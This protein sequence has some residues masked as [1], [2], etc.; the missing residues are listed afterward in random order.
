MNE[1]KNTLLDC[2]KIAKE[3]YVEVTEK[4]GQL[5]QELTQH[6]ET[7]VDAVFSLNSS[8]IENE[9]TYRVL[10]DIND[11][12][13]SLLQDGF[14]RFENSFARKHKNLSNFTVTLFGRTKAGKSTI[15]EALTNGDGTSIGKGAQRTTRDVKEYFWNHLRILDTPG[16]DAYKGIEDEKMAFSQ[17]DQTDLILFLVTSDSIEESEFK[18]LAHIRRENKPVIILLN[19]LYDLNHP[20]KRKRFLKNP[21]K[22]VSL[23]AIEGHLH[24]LQFLSKKHFNIGNIEIIPIHALAAYESNGLIGEEKDILYKAS[25]FEY[26]KRTITSNIQSTGKQKRV[27]SFRDS[28]ISHLENSI[29]SIYAESCET[30]GPQ[31]VLMR[32][33]QKELSRWF[34]NFIPEKNTEIEQKIDELYD[35]L[36]Q[37]LDSFIDKHIQN[38]HFGKK[39]NQKVNSEIT[40]AQ[41]RKIY[42]SITN[43]ANRYLKEFFSEFQFDLDLSLSELRSELQGVKKGTTA[44]TVKWSGAAIGTASAIILSTMVANSWNPIGWGLAAVAAG[45][46]IFRMFYDD[47]TKRFNR[48]KARIKSNILSSLRKNKIELRNLLK[49][50]FSREITEGLK[51]KIVSDLNRQTIKLGNLLKEYEAIT[52]NIEKEI[53]RANFA[54][55]TR[56]L[57]LQNIDGSY[58]IKEIQ[59]IYRVQG[60]MSKLVLAENFEFLSTSDRQ[61]FEKVFG[62]KIVDVHFS[63]D[64]KQYLLNS[65]TVE[66]E[67]VDKISYEDALI[68]IDVKQMKAERIYGSEGSNLHLA[69]KI[70]KNKIQ[71][72]L[73]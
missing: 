50:W 23:E 47:D 27:Q 62:E 69:Q 56:L 6:Q 11:K 28:Y 29:K 1:Y 46:G 30:L 67:D 51:K 2:S 25:N 61:V 7:L 58:K 21:Q 34:N 22:A 55:M 49:S 68:T 60:L 43:D 41:I 38:P 26:F 5:K 18:K 8:S 24:R 44:K 39:W 3:E 53:E 72:N 71:V 37:D 54:L 42:E 59:N 16:F 36:F 9:S 70:L 35:P 32:K 19:V 14:T 17:L 12:T 64:R 33:K 52:E 66:E 57:A 45:L 31:V 10:H 15:R 4:L 20:I 63:T 73:I 40:E 48:E 13:T 65:L